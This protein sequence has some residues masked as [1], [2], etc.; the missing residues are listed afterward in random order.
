MTGRISKTLIILLCAG[1]QTWSF[2]DLPPGQ[3]KAQIP[4]TSRIDTTGRIIDKTDYPF[5]ND[6]DV[7]GI[8]RSVDF[9]NEIDVF[10]P[11]KKHWRGALFLK[12]LI[13]IRNGKM[14][15]MGT[16][17]RSLVLNEQDKTASRYE[18]KT[19][20][21]VPYM[22]FEWKS[23]D[24]FLRHQKP[25]Y[26]VLRKVSGPK[27]EDNISDNE[28]N[29]FQ[30][31]RP[32][33]AVKPFD[34]VRWKDMSKLILA[35]RPTLPATLNFN[36]ATLWPEA[37]KMPAGCD[38]QQL[39]KNAMNP[40]LGIRD[41]HRRGITGKG[42]S[43]A[44]ID[45][46]MFL[47][48]PEF[49][50]KVAE[51]YDTGCGAESSMHGP[52]VASLL[53]GKN[54]GVAPEAR[55]YYAAVPSWKKDSDY[56]A[57]ALEWIIQKNKKLSSSEKIRVVSV[58]AAPSGDATPY[59][60]NT[61]LWDSVCARAEKE[62]I[63][64]LDCT[65]HHGIIGPCWYNPADPEN[66]T[67]CTLGFPGM[68]PEFSNPRLDC[69]YV[70]KSPRTV[71]EEYDKGKFAYAYWGNGGLSWAIPYTAGILALGWQIAPDLPAPR[72]RDLLL[73]SAYRT[74]NGVSI[75]NPIEFIRQ[76]KETKSAKHKGNS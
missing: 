73:H 22:F 43:V 59:E 5:E 42:V 45:Q 54:C 35:D 64:V 68:A 13:F 23:G 44:I 26:Y 2:A 53:V 15:P 33:T 10:Q 39:L 24:Y 50:G 28:K 74:P 20:D 36:Q 21:R 56:Y 48:H 40:G 51:Y 18:I 37:S 34:D 14:K 3:E 65:S 16:W 17:T 9:V 29:D 62:G 7:L 47:D 61:A 49:A 63:L 6:P 27:K 32:I 12:K 66:V 46:P 69:L 67:K 1:L 8:W 52:A 72:M 76:V 70:P 38:P 30:A 4:S 57:K 55:L 60:K 75:I 19:F 11:G 58:S 25:S 41:L 31:I 71:A